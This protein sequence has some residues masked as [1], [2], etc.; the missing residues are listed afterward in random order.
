MWEGKA[1]NYS[2]K[3]APLDIK[4]RINS[5]FSFNVRKPAPALESDDMVAIK[6]QV[7]SH[8]TVDRMVSASVALPESEVEARK[9]LKVRFIEMD[10]KESELLEKK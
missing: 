7:K 3:T 5:L 2:A 10:G 4:T 6:D 9:S 1:G 8:A